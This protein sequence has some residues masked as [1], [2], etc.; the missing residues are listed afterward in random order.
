[1]VDGREQGGG[2]T[3]RKTESEWKEEREGGERRG[4]REKKEEEKVE[5]EMVDGG[6]VVRG[7]GEGER[8]EGP[9]TWEKRE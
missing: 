9:K 6:D 8:E 5:K 2:K 7:G 3:R 4:E 1:M